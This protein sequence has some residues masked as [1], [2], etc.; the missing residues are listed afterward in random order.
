MH[1]QVYETGTPKRLES[2]LGKSRR[3]ERERRET[4]H[5]RAPNENEIL[6]C[7][8]EDTIVR[9]PS[10]VSHRISMIRKDVSQLDLSKS[11]VGW[12]GLK[13]ETNEEDSVQLP[14]PPFV[15][16]YRFRVLTPIRQT[17]TNLSF[18]TLAKNSPE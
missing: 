1:V 9:R 14:S 7:R 6:R 18:P 11:S 15:Y 12:F 2:Q 5:L 10:E 3:R 17:T 4:N 16:R 13:K 8:Q